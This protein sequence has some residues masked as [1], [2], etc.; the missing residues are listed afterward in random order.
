VKA[1][2][3][4][5]RQPKRNS[6]AYVLPHMQDEAAVKVEALLFG[7]EGLSIGEHLHSALGPP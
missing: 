6:A 5:C 4:T 3:N 7:E 2:A 1:A